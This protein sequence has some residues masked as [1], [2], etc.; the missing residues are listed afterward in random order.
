M[1]GGV[2]PSAVQKRE[3]GKRQV[4]NGQQPLMMMVTAVDLAKEKNKGR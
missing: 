1:T 4:T 2:H 3:R